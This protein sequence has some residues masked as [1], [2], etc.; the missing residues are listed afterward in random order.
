M[1]NLILQHRSLL[2]PNRCRFLCIITLLIASCAMSQNEPSPEAAYT[3]QALELVRQ[4]DVQQALDHILSLE[5][6]SRADLIEITQIPAPP[7]GEGDRALKL[8]ELLKEAGLNEVTVDEVGNVIGKRPGTR[9]NRVV[10]YSAHLDTVFPL[11]TDL[12]V[13]QEGNRLYAPGIGDNSRGLI[14]ILTVLRA[15]QFAQLKTEADVWFIGNV[16]EEG[17]GDL[18]GMKHLFREGAD[19]IHSLIAVDGGSASRIV[20][21]G[22]GS[23]RYRVTFAGPGGHSWGAFGLANPHHAMGRAIALFD[24][25]ALPV[26]RE[27]PKTSYNVGRLGGGTSV[28]SIPFEAWMEVDMRS[29][30]QE[31]LNQIDAVFQSAMQQ[32]LDQENTERE[33]GPEL[34]LIIE[35]VGTRPAATGDAAQPI[36]QR[37]MAA[38]KAFGITPDLQISSTDAN[39]PISKGIPA[40]TMSRGGRGGNSHSPE[41]WWENDDGH[42]SIQIGLITLLT[43][44]GYVAADP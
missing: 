6:R 16:G 14:T 2:D 44:A 17:L 18:R 32:A 15:M 29:G 20:Y 25:Q 37:A 5:P 33:T 40:I 36:V 28:N 1:T 21:G 39:L 27:G 41:E 26:T 35:R 31:K 12:T 42:I 11:E 43:E 4:N 9:G 7:F 22:V 3:D 19:R 34:S 23:H 24:E 30:S 38:T 8:Q 13:R 10:A